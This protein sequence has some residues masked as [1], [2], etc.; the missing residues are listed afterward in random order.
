M[1][2]RLPSRALASW[3]RVGTGTVR[4]EKRTRSLIAVWERVSCCLSS[5]RLYGFESLRSG[6]YPS[7]MFLRAQQAFERCEKFALSFHW[8][9]QREGALP[10]GQK[11]KQRKTTGRRVAPLAP[12]ALLPTNFALHCVFLLYWWR[13][14]RLFFKQCCGDYVAAATKHQCKQR[15]R[16]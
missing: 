16:D 4:A 13:E 9:A 11:V 10:T 15:S 8:S 3:L 14:D 7:G 1:S 5:G 12:H 2:M 6:D